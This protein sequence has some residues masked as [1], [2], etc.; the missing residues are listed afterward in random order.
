MTSGTSDDDLVPISVRL[1]QVVPPEDPEDWTRPLTW[2]AA[3][4]M[5][6]GP[7]IA[8]V[9]F[10]VGPPTDTSRALPATYLVAG[11]LVGGAAATG[12]TQIGAARAGTAT[13]GAGLFGALVTIV[14]GVATAGERQLGA[15]SPTLAHAFVAVVAGLAGAFIAAIVA[16]MV[17]GWRSRIVRLLPAIVVGA[18]AALAVLRLLLPS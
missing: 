13:L 11:A 9:W 7:I 2:V 8:L 6:V 14:L 16:A 10:I 12:A 4:G 17:A 5:L 15:A 1:G 3:L 18:A